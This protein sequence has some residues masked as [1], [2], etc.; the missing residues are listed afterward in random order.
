MSEEQIADSL[1]AESLRTGKMISAPMTMG[2]E[3]ALL[4]VSDDRAYTKNEILIAGRDTDENGWIV[5][6]YL[7]NAL[8]AVKLD[9]DGNESS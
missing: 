2:L 1:I 6:L 7:P 3:I 4:F 9:V 5:R 8:D